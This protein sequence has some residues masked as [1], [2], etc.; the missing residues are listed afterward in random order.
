MNLLK[1]YSKIDE[2]FELKTKRG[3]LIKRY[4]EV[5]KKMGNDL[6]FHRMYA[7][8]YI[9]K[10]FYNKLKSYLPK[11]F[12]FNIIKYNEKNRTI[13]FI[14][15]PDFNES[16]EPIV[17][18]A[19]KVTEDGNTTLTR[20]KRIPQIYHHK[21]MFVKDD[22]NRFDVDKSKERSA[23]WLKISDKINMSKIGTKNYW[24]DVVLP[25]L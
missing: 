23:R 25:L 22:Y 14:N 6:Y 15:S 11:D 16:D 20:Q 2:S 24:E 1:Q 10:D 9:D 3:S 13:S 12:D 18:D 5:G 17:G 7:D 21:W 4:K 19:M 8:D